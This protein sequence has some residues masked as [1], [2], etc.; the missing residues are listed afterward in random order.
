MKTK[1]A[2]LVMLSLALAGCATTPVPSATY[3]AKYPLCAGVPV[4]FLGCK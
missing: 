4:G 1:I 2:L 3:T